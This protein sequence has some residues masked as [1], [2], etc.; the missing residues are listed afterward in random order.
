MMKMQRTIVIEKLQYSPLVFIK[1]TRMR[2]CDTMLCTVL[3]LTHNF[4]ILSVPG[5]PRNIRTLGGLS[6]TPI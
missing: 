6:A 4:L 5:G 1:T 2:V 3:I